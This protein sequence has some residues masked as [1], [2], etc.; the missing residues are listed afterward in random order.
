[1]RRGAGLPFYGIFLVAT[2][3]HGAVCVR[4]MPDLAAVDRAALAADQLIR[5][6]AGCAGVPSLSCPALHFVLRQIEHLR[7]DD[8]RMALFYIILRYFALVELGFLT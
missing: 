1:M 7:T 2:P 4:A 8:G 6:D 5:E 3:N